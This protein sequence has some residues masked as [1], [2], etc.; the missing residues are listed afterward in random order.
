MQKKH[1]LEQAAAA[2]T[3]SVPMYQRNR[4]PGETSTTFPR[5]AETETV[6][7]NGS[8]SVSSKAAVDLSIQKK[9]KPN[10]KPNMHVEL[11]HHQFK[12]TDF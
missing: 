2:G 6:D 3:A 10:P 8:L 4:E 5:D 7:A 9:I 12:S 11:L 1:R